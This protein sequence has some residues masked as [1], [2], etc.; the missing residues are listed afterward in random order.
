M[1]RSFFLPVSGTACWD[2]DIDSL[3]QA[4]DS[5][6]GLL[7]VSLEKPTPQ[8]MQLY[9]ADIFHFHPLAIEDSHSIGYQTPKV[10]D[11]E[12]YLFII[13]HALHPDHDFDI[14]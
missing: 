6:A 10:D 9:L 11:Y 8:E 3:K 12:G 7:W 4:I 1:V 5:K 2:L 14:L 13:A